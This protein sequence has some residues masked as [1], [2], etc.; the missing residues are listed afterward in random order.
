MMKSVGSARVHKYTNTK[1]KRTHIHKHA[2]VGLST[3]VS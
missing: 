2:M 1:N 3:D